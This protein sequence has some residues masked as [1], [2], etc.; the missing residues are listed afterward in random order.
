M[1]RNVAG[2]GSTGLEPQT[3]QEA[4]REISV[5]PVRNALRGGWVGGWIR[6]CPVEL[7]FVSLRTHCLHSTHQSAEN[8]QKDRHVAPKCTILF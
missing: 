1:G 3:S 8:V 5:N 6:E 2:R 7:M 4:T